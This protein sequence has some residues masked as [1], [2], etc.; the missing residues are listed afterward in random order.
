VNE[1]VIE[2]IQRLHRDIRNASVSL[3]ANE[4]RFL[5][6][7]YYTMQED[8]KRAYN[9]ERALDDVGEP[10]A[11]IGWLAEQAETLEKQIARALD[12]Y[13]ASKPVGAWARSVDGIGPIIA[14]GLLAHIDI[15]KAPTAGHIWAFAGLDPTRTWEAG[16][17]RPWN[18]KL[19]TLCWKIGESF[20]KVSNKDS[21]F[22]G[23][24]Y[25]ERKEL[26]TVRNGANEFAAQAEAKLKK[27]KIGKDTDAYKHY[28]EGRLPPAHIHARAKRYAVKLF[29]AHYQEIAYTA[30]FGV[31]P[32]APYP[33]AILGHAH[34]IDPPRPELLEST[35]KNE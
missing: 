4:A 17:R 27:F 15:T 34:K 12:A 33:I 30:H 10:A 2:P 5:V 20:V 6:D 16:C 29:L 26:E 7:Q 14:A 31:A 9:Q 22:Y 18:A 1:A 23:R 11:V 35:I 19:K 28:S 25:R 8:R 13:S 21:A 24:I 3:S 32:P